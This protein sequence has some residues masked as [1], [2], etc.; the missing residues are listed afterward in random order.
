MTNLLSRLRPR[1]MAPALALALLGGS[2]VAGAETAL[3][4]AQGAQSEVAQMGK[5]LSTGDTL[6]RSTRSASLSTP[7]G[8]RCT[9]FTRSM[10]WC[11]VLIDWR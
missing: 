11:A 4:I 9:S 2:A 6:S 5:M 7:M 3:P 10:C 8:S 1:L